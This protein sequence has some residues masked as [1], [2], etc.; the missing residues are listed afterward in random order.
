V[1]AR[2]E[3]A[4]ERLWHTTYR[5]ARTRHPPAQRA[6]GRVEDVLDEDVLLVLD[7]HAAHAE[8]G[9]A[10]LHEED[11]HGAEEQPPGGGGAAL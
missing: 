10:G 4:K 9:E 7:L 2:R 3:D 8:H 11:E 6:D 1:S 5:E